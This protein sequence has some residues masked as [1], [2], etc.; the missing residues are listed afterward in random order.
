MTNLK[1]ATP[2]NS[3]DA[4]GGCQVGRRSPDGSARQE[5]RNNKARG[6]GGNAAAWLVGDVI[7]QTVCEAGTQCEKPIR[8]DCQA[9]GEQA[10]SHEPKSFV[11]RRREDGME[12]QVTLM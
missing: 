12:H 4:G 7:R 6:P 5:E 8:G 9:C 1:S 10:H 2:D 3:S 11:E